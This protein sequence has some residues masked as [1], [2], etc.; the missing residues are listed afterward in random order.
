VTLRIRAVNS[1]GV[2][3]ASNALTTTPRLAVDGVRALPSDASVTLLFDPYPGAVGMEFQL[4]RGPGATEV[5]VPWRATGTNTLEAA[6]HLFELENG[7]LVCAQ[8][9]AVLANSERGPASVPVCF[10]PTANP[11]RPEAEPE[12]VVPQGVQRIKREADGSLLVSFTYRVTNTSGS[13]MPSVW[14][15]TLDL[16]AG[17]S[18]VAVDAD[19]GPGELRI[20]PWYE[21][22]W[23]WQ[24][25]NLAAGAS[26]SLSVTVRVRGDR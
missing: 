2:G 8:L 16:P 15:R 19:S 25:L 20:F 21:Q 23:F 9:R 12:V 17:A 3:P 26:R 24:D 5:L 13:E 1:A 7:R 10:T 18:V 22:H 4:L 14:V 11:V 6:L